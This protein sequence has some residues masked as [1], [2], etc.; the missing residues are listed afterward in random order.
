MIKKAVLPVA[1]FGTRFL[2]ASKA[3]PKEMLA[4]IDKPLLQYAVE[5][6][7]ESGIQ[8]IIFI[9][10]PEKISIKKHFEKNEKIE[11]WLKNSGKADL[12]QKLN[13]SA[14]SEI[15][16]SYVNQN[17]QNG[18]G[19]AILQA[20]SLIE[21][22]PFA[23]LLPDDLFISKKSCLR[24]LIEIHI[25]TKLSVIALNKVDKDD[26]HKYGVIKPGETNGKTILIEDIIE[27]PSPQ[28]AP[29]DIAACGR[30]ILNPS[31]FKHLKLIKSDLTGEIQLT[32]AIKSLLSEEKVYGELYEG[33]KFD[34]GSK[35]GY[36][37][38][39]IALALKDETLK[40]DIKNIIKDIF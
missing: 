3:T 23:I 32:D 30:Y 28:T 31:I 29:S 39:T 24:Q 38:A 2:P 26:I 18:L 12:A 10:N 15:K 5:E 14:F 4:I 7:I 33:Q 27:K 8:E 9:T 25:K 37:H 35:K 34:C 6:A 16:F 21:N 17:Q 1:G 19:H 36:V 22:Q 20:E 13:P 11:S 40:E